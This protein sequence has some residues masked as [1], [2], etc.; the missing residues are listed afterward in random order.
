MRT[1]PGR[2]F[3]VLA[4]LLVAGLVN[5][6]GLGEQDQAAVELEV[7]T[8][9]RGSLTS[10]ITAVGTVRAGTEVILSFEAPGRVSMVAVQDG[11]RVEEGQLRA[12]THWLQLDVT[13]LAPG[14]YFCRVNAGGTA[15]TRRLMVV[16]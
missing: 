11:E 15:M 13:G 4:L 1:G 9:E 16:R 2:W 10:S 8:V 6:C 12:G 5:G 3:L 7:A 14:M